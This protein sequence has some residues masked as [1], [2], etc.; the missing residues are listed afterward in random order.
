MDGKNMASIPVSF[1]HDG[2]TYKRV[3]T[4]RDIINARQSLENA[5]YFIRV[6]VEGEPVFSRMAAFLY[7]HTNGDTTVTVDLG[8]LFDLPT[9]ID[10][11]IFVKHEAMRHVD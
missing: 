10:E 5:V 6:I 3:G 11:N 4:L 1:N 7:D 2:A 8:C 9:C